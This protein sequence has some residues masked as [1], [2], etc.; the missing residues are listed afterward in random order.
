MKSSQNYASIAKKLIYQTLPKDPNILDCIAITERGIHFPYFRLGNVRDYLQTHSL[1]DR[2][3]DRWIGNAID[4]IITIH[5]YGIVHS[6]ISARKLLVADDFSIKLCDFA[7]SSIN[8]LKSLV[9]EE[10]AYHSLPSSP[11]TFKTDLFALG[12]LI[13]EISTGIRLFAD[14]ED[15][16]IERKYAAQEFPSLRDVFCEGVISKCWRSQYSCA[17]MLKRDVLRD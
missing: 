16:E 1:D 7:G 3:R 4:A 15:D 8:D 13:Y 2:T 6:D 5:A 14:I 12:S 9:A 17:N 10:T 11:R